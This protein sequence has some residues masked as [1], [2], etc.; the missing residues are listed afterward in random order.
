MKAIRALGVLF[1]AA[2]MFQSC[3]VSVGVGHGHGH[4]SDWG[5]HHGGWHHGG[6]HH[7][8]ALGMEPAEELA[9]DFGIRVESAQTI[10][11]IAQNANDEQIAKLGIESTDLMALAQLQ[12]PSHESIEKVAKALNEEPANIEKVAQSFVSDVRVQMSDVKGEYWQD[13]IHSGHWITPQNARC[14]Q[15][16]WEGCTPETGATSCEIAE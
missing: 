2:M 1:V 10:L 16:S 13:C 9:R 8:N 15:E 12:I 3:N 11:N 7:L 6:H 5:W 14:N 4:G